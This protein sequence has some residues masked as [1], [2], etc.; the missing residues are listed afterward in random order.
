MLVS[1]DHGN[2]EDMGTKESNNT[3]HTLNP[4]PLVGVNTDKEFE[5]GELWEIENIIE[6]LIDL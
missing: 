2:C 1:A 4:V 5:D 3:S 6:D